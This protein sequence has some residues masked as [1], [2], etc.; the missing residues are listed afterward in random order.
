MDLRELSLVRD[1]R[2]QDLNKLGVYC[3]EDLVRFYPKTYLDMTRCVSVLS[4]YHNDM[5]L[6][7]CSV[8]NVEYV[9]GGGKKSYVR[10]TCVQEGCSFAAFW[11]NQPYVYKILKPGDYYFYGRVQKKYSLV[12][13]IAN[14][15]FERADAENN[16]LSGIAPVY[17]VAGSLTQ[18][19]M[20]SL[21]KQALERTVL[22]SAIP[23]DIIKKH[24]LMPLDS[25]Y[26]A[27]HFPRAMDEIE[28]ASARIATEEYFILISALRIIKGDR[29]E[30]GPNKYTVT[31]GDVRD[32]TGRFP[33]DFTKGQKDAVNDIYRDLHGEFRMNR[34]IQGDVGSGKTAV[35]LTA[36]YMAV[37]SGFQAA[38]LSPTEVLARQTAAL[39][40]KFFPD[41]SV[42]FLSGST[43]AKD[44]KEIKA[45]IKEGRADIVCGTHA[46]IQ[47]DVEFKR[48]ALAV[49][50]EQQ[51][52]GVAQRS[53]LSDKGEGCD[54]LVM[55]ATPI[56][57]TL[58]LIFYG[59]LDITT[60]KDK[61]NGRK[62]ISTSVI[63]EERYDDMVAYVAREAKLGRQSYFV[64]PKIDED[65]EGTLKSVTELYGELKGKMPGV[66]VALLHGRMSDAEKTEI[67]QDFK[68][69]KYDCLVSTTVIEVGIDVSS[70]TI[71][72]INNAERFGLSQL[73][74]LRGRVGR[75][76]DKSYCFLIMGVDSPDARK[77]L[78]V[79]VNCSDG[80]EIAESD[81]ELRGGGDFIGLRQSGKMMTDIK[82]LRYGVET[83]ID[84]KTLVDEMFSGNYDMESIK[85]VAYRK[86]ESLKDI[87]LN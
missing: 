39:M 87:V 28:P 69:K 16:R 30:L 45:A 17:P 77:R 70:A 1:K 41:C 72:V 23:D 27:V 32:F 78:D 74:Q 54:V 58:S 7:H 21:V 66:K 76:A 34:L 22:N 83:V 25:A 65:E 4:C 31:A 12:G 85:A 79:L 56:P 60:I 47:K 46:I 80:F 42:A 57:R 61:P 36:I 18:G 6:T 33:F 3:V 37:K 75:G 29:K 26:R 73:H 59:D 48:L 51:R 53:G 64:C 19:V 38:M 81:L 10:A 67:M 63:P 9:R 15:L 86:Y 14:P 40:Q 55:S 20:R 24:G 52:F 35:A 11:F 13:S 49:C 82:N 8:T 5:I 84:T 68:D 44:K 62:A 43:K 71:M 50:D 2:E